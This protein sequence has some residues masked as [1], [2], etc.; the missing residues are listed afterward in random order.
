MVI[1]AQGLLKSAITAKLLG[2]NRAGF[3][4]DS[5]REGV[6]SYF[7]HE[8]IEIAYDANTIDRNAKVM[9]EPLNIHI[10]EK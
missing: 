4:K 7:Y 3:S 6:A 5:I 8:K 9:S 2:K 10:T 1:D